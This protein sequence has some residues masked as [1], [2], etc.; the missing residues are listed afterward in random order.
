MANT[1][2]LKVGARKAHKRTSRRALKDLHASMSREERKAFRKEEKLTLKVFLKKRREEEARAK[3]KEA[4]AA[5]SAAATSA[6][7]TSE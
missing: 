5:A 7:A 3:K 4:E 1:K 6:P 2:K